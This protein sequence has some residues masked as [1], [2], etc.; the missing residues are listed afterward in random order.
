[1]SVFLEVAEE[2]WIF[3]NALAFAFRGQLHSAGSRSSSRHSF[4]SGA[5]PSALPAPH[6]DVTIT[7]KIL[8]AAR[9]MLDAADERWVDEHVADNPL[10]EQI[11]HASELLQANPELA[12]APAPTVPAPPQT[13]VAPVPLA[14]MSQRRGGAAPDSCAHGPPTRGGGRHYGLEADR[15]DQESR[16][17]ANTSRNALTRRLRR[18]GTQPVRWFEV[19]ATR[20]C[21][22]SV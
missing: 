17:F 15:E 6:V 12:H 10:F 14:S 20:V 13:P 2:A 21:F 11:T 16:G 7:V 8:P 1:M 4:F 9:R 18:T 19:R 5:A 22:G 3:A